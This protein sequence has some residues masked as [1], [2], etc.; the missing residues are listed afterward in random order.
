MKIK[1]HDRG[2][3]LAPGV[4]AIT[5]TKYGTILLNEATNN[6]LDL[7]P[8]DSVFI[9][10]DEDNPRDF[11]ISK[12]EDPDHPK[13]IKLR[14]F[15]NMKGGLQSSFKELCR[16]INRT[17]GHLEKSTVKY[18]ISKEPIQENGYTMFPIITRGGKEIIRRY[19][20][21]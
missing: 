16:L 4:P 8:G 15:A 6:L 2:Q 1:I 9:M 19:G 13:G 5:F 11:Y 14:R 17:N 10:Q 7:D 21:A 3:C 20:N 18:Q 12:S